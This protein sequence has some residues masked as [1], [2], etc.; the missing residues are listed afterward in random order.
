MVEQAQRRERTQ[1]T[2]LTVTRELVQE[3]GCEQMTLTDIMERSGLSRGGIYHY[4]KSKDELFAAVLRAQIEATDARFAEKVKQQIAHETQDLAGPMQEIM[5]SLAARSSAE[6]EVTQQ[7]FLYL[8][9]KRGDEAVHYLLQQFYDQGKQ[10]SREWLEIGQAQGVISLAVDTEK[11]AD[12]FVLISYGMRMT[13]QL[14]EHHFTAADFSALA[15]H[16]LVGD[17]R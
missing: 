13:A 5:A 10:M 4:V 16:L 6:D 15:T 17:G 8:L 11:L 7:I 14:T 9:A 2:L 3:K 1:Q 12:L